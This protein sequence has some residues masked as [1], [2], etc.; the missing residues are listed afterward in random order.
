MTR[1]HLSSAS[2]FLAVLVLTGFAA[3]PNA[4]AQNISISSQ[5]GAPSLASRGLQLA[6][7]GHCHE[8]LPI[9]ARALPHI[10]DHATKYEA[11]IAMAQCSM[12]LHDVSEALYN[13][14]RLNRD[15]P[16]DPQVLYI[17]THFCGEMAKNASTELAKK[18]P[19]SYQAQELDAEAYE[20]NGKW[21]DALAEYKRVLQQYPKLPDIHYRIGRVILSMPSTP[22]TAR[23]AKEQFE[24]ELKINPSNAAAEFMLGDLDRQLEQWDQAVLHFRH[25]SQLDVGFLEADLGLGMALNAEGKYQEAIPPLQKYIAGVPDDA[26]GHYQL[27]MAY[28]RTGHRDEAEHELARQRELD[29]RVNKSNSSDEKPP[30]PRR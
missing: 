9:L 22:T 12:S 2:L 24:A 17:T 13:L 23:D 27:A 26:A 18:D 11:E 5:K 14:G 21:S 16:D 15:F 7:S 20:A 28:A 29:A 30:E 6:N 1:P 19:T 8:A 3:A 25:A 10:A 4:A